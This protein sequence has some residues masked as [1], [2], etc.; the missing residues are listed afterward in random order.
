MKNHKAFLDKDVFTVIS[1]AAKTLGA[2]AYVIGGFV[3]GVLLVNCKKSPI[4]PW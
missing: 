3:A 1:S 4:L 2:D